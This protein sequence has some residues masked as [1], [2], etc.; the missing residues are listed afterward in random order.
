MKFTYTLIFLLL[1]LSFLSAQEVIKQ[2]SDTLIQNQILEKIDANQEASIFEEEVLLQYMLDNGII[3]QGEKYYRSKRYKEAFH[4]F[5]KDLKNDSQNHRLHYKIGIT[6]IYCKNNVLALKH[7]NDAINLAPDNFLYYY[8]RGLAK[9]ILKNRFSAIS[10]F[11]KSIKL[12]PSHGPS[13][14]YLAALNYK[15]I[16]YESAMYYCNKTI[17]FMPN[18]ARAYHRRAVTYIALNNKEAAI[19]DLQ[20]AKKLDI[21]YANETEV[22][23]LLQL[24]LDEI[25]DT[26][27]NYY[28]SIKVKSGTAAYY[29]NRGNL[30]LDAKRYKDAIIDYEKSISL[31]S[32]FAEAYHGIG[33]VYACIKDYPTAIT[34][35]KKAIELDESPDKSNYNLGKLYFDTEQYNKAILSFD[36]A[37]AIETHFPRAYFYRGLAK[38]ELGQ[39]VE[40]ERDIAMTLKQK[41]YYPEAKKK[42]KKI[43]KKLK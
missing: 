21:E 36:K 6:A 43:Q 24:L 23:D 40:A 27:A 31:D 20:T 8:G 29:T 33:Q 22:N 13:Y 4:E 1:T 7:F 9:T 11:K 3:S 10:D 30:K 41:P 15:L 2:S 37:I 14:E 26:G 32:M 34:Y 19:D 25:E 17:E 35:L 18:S 5:K 38:E 12:N 39:I 28:S 42:L 16:R